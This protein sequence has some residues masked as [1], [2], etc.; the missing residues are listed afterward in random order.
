MNREHQQQT[1]QEQRSN[2]AALAALLLLRE[3]I[4]EESPSLTVLEMY[5]QPRPFLKVKDT[6]HGIVI[7]FSCEADY[8]TYVAIVSQ[9]EEVAHHV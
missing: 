4:E 1:P 3:C 9:P 5:T 8:R 2:A 6:V 7:G